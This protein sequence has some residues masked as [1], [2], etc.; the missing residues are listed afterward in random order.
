M[1]YQIAN[2]WRMILTAVILI[3]LA[4]LA[5]VKG[6]SVLAEDRGTANAAPRQTVSAPVAVTAGDAIAPAGAIQA[7]QATPRPPGTA[8]YHTVQA[9]ET[10]GKIAAQY[11]LTTAALARANG[12]TN[13]DLIRAGQRLV[14]PA[15]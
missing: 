11:G 9:G 15:H 7:I 14:I 12:I 13:P 5:L 1:L 6:V 8:T 4:A 2:Q 3:G 10:L